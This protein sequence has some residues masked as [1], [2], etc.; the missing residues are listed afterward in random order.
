MDQHAAE[1]LKAELCGKSVGGWVV[2][3]YINH[4]KSAAVF[5]AIK[6]GQIAALKVF[7]PELVNR[8]GRDNQRKRIE[9]ERSLVG[10]SH[11]NLVQIYDGGEDG[12]Y[13]YVAMEFFPGKNLADVLKEIPEREIRP[14]MAQIAAAAKF[15]ED[16]AYAHRDI[17]PENIG[18]SKD[19]KRAKLLDLGVIRPFDLSNV[20]D[21]GEQRFFVGTLQYSPPELLFC[22]EDQSLEG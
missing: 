2:E 22:E 3:E 10:R 1:K 11:P 20:T 21:E 6:G 14:L 13:L 17:K 19:M 16:A 5:R 8:Y 15:L 9:R 12:E 4:G 7:D 18:I